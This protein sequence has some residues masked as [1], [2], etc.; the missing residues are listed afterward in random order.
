DRWP[1]GVWWV[2]LALMTDGAQVAPALASTVGVRPLPG[3]T[4]LEA[5]VDHLRPRRALVVLDNCEHLLRAAGDTA[6]AIVCG[7]PGVS[8]LVTSRAPLG[9]AGETDWRVPSLSLAAEEHGAFPGASESG[10][11]FIERARKVRPNFVATHENAPVIEQICRDLDGIPLAIELAAARVR[12]L[13][14]QQIAAGVADRFRILTAGDHRGIPRHR[15][16]RASVDWSYGLLSDDERV[17]FHRL[18][19]FAGGWTLDAV[20]GVCSGDGL[21]AYAILD[22]LRSLVDKSLVLVEE[23]GGSMRYRMLETVRQY[24]LERLVASGEEEMVRDRHRDFFSGL[25]E[26]AEPELVA[27][28]QQEWLT[29][30]DAESAN[31]AAALDRA[32]ETAPLLALRASAALTLWWKLRGLFASADLA[33]A[34]AIEAAQ[35]G[36]AALRARVLWGRAYLR[37]Y[38]GDWQGA[39]GA[40]E[41]ALELAEQSGDRSTIARALDVLGTISFLPDPLG[42]RPGQ[43]RSIALGRECG[44]DWVV[45]DATQIL[46]YAHLFTDELREAERLLRGVLPV[47]ERMRYGEFLA[48]HWWGMSWRPL[49]AGE[50]ELFVELSER[51]LAAARGVGEPVT[52]G[53]AHSFL[54]LAE[55]A[56]G[57]AEEALARLEASVER[58]VATG[59]GMALAPTLAVLGL[60]RAALGDAEGARIRLED[61]TATGVD[62]GYNLAWALASLAEVLRAA[63]DTTQAARRAREALEIGE[64]IGTPRFV[65]WPQE[66]LGRLAA[67]DGRWAEADALLHGAL[68]HWSDLGVRLWVPRTLDALAE[69]AANLESH[70]EAARLVGAAERGYAAMGLVR[71]APDQP[72]AD[73]VQRSLRT[74]MGDE[75]FEAARNEGTELTLDEAIAWCRRARGARRRPSAGWEALTP[76]EQTVVE[77][78]TEGLS[79]RQIGQR[80]F[81]SPATVKVHLAHIFRKLNVSTRTQLAAHAARRT[82]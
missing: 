76:T 59:A 82:V 27:S 20:E 78:V 30:L 65:G 56:Q 16:L 29:I 73:A 38:G 42:C 44:D 51:A 72:A 24:A 71:W 45:A 43:E 40:G 41:E 79:N 1:D 26:R 15:T 48:W 80:M 77:L 17:L 46:A 63:G 14:P 32:A 69:V 12:M 49:W 62:G 8:V 58:V 55:L 68:D 39:L 22:L 10:C 50:L 81:I 31:L 66:V 47:I 11:L 54:A 52:E 37:V 67:A 35:G 21:D 36:H 19:V 13:T 34:R 4:E 2:E 57:H 70:R 60:T 18:A 74:A 6:E 25:A 23:A 3:R 28:H 7:C 33:Y 53:M 64:R 5:V 61:L 9:L 75:A